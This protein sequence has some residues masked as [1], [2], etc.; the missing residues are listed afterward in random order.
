MVSLTVFNSLFMY[1]YIMVHVADLVQY[2]R[3]M[4]FLISFPANHLESQSISGLETE[5][6]KLRNLGRIKN[7][8]ID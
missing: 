6:T 3:P 4:Q 2:S 8:V 5:I 1:V 7:A